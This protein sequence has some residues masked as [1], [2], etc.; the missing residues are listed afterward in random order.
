[1]SM[2][3]F[4]TPTRLVYR[5]ENTTEFATR[6]FEL[7]TWSE[8]RL[9]VP[10]TQLPARIK[11][12][13]SATALQPVENVALFDVLGPIF[14]ADDMV[15]TKLQQ[16]FGVVLAQQVLADLLQ[17][18]PDLRNANMSVDLMLNEKL[19][20]FYTFFQQLVSLHMQLQ[21]RFNGIRLSYKS[22]AAAMAGN[23]RTMC[24]VFRH[25]QIK[26]FEVH[27]TH[28]PTA[29]LL[30]MRQDDTERVN[31]RVEEHL[32]NT[33]QSHSCYILTSGALVAEKDRVRKQLQEDHYESE[34]NM[35]DARR[36]ISNDLDQAQAK[37]EKLIVAS[38]NP[39]VT[40]VSDVD[41]EVL[42]ELRSK[43]KAL[44]EQSK[45]RAENLKYDA[46]YGFANACNTV[47][48]AVVDVGRAAGVTYY[49]TEKMKM[50]AVMGVIGV[51]GNVISIAGRLVGV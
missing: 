20:D 11:N 5:V 43:L 48:R 12:A 36:D 8:D 4:A 39:E 19:N 28:H 47:F 10:Y 49:E 16:C 30:D 15:R 35:K 40:G 2:Q 33:M 1:M 45:K 29:Y 51:A 24:R 34:K 31:P 23:Y 7:Q 41:Q 21:R 44:Q 9:I 13:L 50:N 14:N 17:K 42:E 46:L 37:L 3:I 32:N 26:T 18:F 25:A 38:D 27:N 22:D 6:L